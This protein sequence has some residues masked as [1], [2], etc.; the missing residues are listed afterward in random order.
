MFSTSLFPPHSMTLPGS[1]T[2][3]IVSPP[4]CSSNSQIFPAAHPF[5]VNDAAFLH[6]RAPSGSISDILGL[7]PLSL[8]ALLRRF[9]LHYSL[10]FPFAESRHTRFKDCPQ[11]LSP[12]F[13]RRCNP[14]IVKVGLYLLDPSGRLYH[15]FD[16]FPPRIGFSYQSKVPTIPSLNS[17]YEVRV[18]YLHVLHC[19]Q[20]CHQLSVCVFWLRICYSTLGRFYVDSFPPLLIRKEANPL[21]FLSF[22]V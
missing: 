8:R 20:P 7:F 16:L 18:R 15:F 22:R 12:P 4:P 3:P 13:F 21:F 14:I 6:E 10:S 2:C 19:G 9:S 11:I 5:P 1:N 17:F